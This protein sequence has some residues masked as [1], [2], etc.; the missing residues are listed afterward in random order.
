MAVACVEF[1]LEEHIVRRLNDVLDKLSNCRAWCGCVCGMS[2]I[3]S[4]F[5]ISFLFLLS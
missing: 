5:L 1:F 3:F 2:Y 4:A